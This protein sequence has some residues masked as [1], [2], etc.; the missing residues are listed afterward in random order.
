MSIQSIEVGGKEV[1]SRRGC[2]VTVGGRTVQLLT[3]Q[4]AMYLMEGIQEALK[5]PARQM[6]LGWASAKLGMN[7][8]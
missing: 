5:E 1:A 4:E 2:E 3:A 8:G 6:V 7:L